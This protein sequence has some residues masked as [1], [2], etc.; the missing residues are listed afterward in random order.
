MEMIDSGP[1]IAIQLQ[2][3][4]NKNLTLHIYNIFRQYSELKHL[5]QNLKR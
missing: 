4:L 5:K 3:L 2:Y 1:D